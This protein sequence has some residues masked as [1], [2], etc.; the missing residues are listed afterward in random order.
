M[1]FWCLIGARTAQVAMVALVLLLVF[2]FPRPRDAVLAKR[3]PPITVTEKKLLG[4]MKVTNTHPD[5]RLQF[6][7]IQTLLGR[8]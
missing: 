5:V 4:L 6:A 7:K 8:L 1:V 2:A 3:Y